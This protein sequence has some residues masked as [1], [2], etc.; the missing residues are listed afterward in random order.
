MR[1]T[2]PLLYH[3][4]AVASFNKWFI[5]C[6]TGGKSTLWTSLVQ[7][8][9]TW[10]IKKRG[11]WTSL[12]PN[13]NGSEI[14]RKFQYFILIKS[15]I[16]VIFILQLVI[17]TFSENKQTHTHTHTHTHNA[18]HRCCIQHV[19]SC[20]ICIY[21]DL[22]LMEREFWAYTRKRSIIFCLLD[23]A[24]K[25]LRHECARVA[26]CV[27]A[28]WR[29]FSHYCRPLRQ[30]DVW[31]TCSEHKEALTAAPTAHGVH[32]EAFRVQGRST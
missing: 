18:I 24:M 2:T 22:C 21:E 29:N 14:D 17:N 3:V 11:Y 9:Y 27:T 6:G 28:R 25:C 20:L 32:K 16:S 1:H 8:F 13:N 5:S 26:H 15:S 23:A 30:Y 31:F 10:L 12:E 7:S 4:H 19:I